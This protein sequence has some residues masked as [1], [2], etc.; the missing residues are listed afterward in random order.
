[1]AGPQA[2][3]A[4]PLKSGSWVQQGWINRRTWVM[5]PAEETPERRRLV[6]TVHTVDAMDRFGRTSRRSGNRMYWPWVLVG[7]AWGVVLLATVT[8]QTRL[9]DHDYLLEHSGLPW[10]AALAVF[11]LCWQVMIAAMML[12]ATLP[13][14]SRDAPAARGSV[15]AAFLTGYAL[16]W[17]WFAAA[18]F[19]GDMVVHLTIESWPWLSTHPAAIGAT[20]LAVAGAVQF[21]PLKRHSLMACRSLLSATV[22]RVPITSDAAWRLG[23]HHGVDCL[24]SGWALM[25][26]MFGLGV[27][28][29]LW[30]VALS[31][32]MVVEKA[33]PSGRWLTPVVGIVLLALAIV[34]WMHPSWLQHVAA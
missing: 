9:I 27:G 3:D 18:A 4:R 10:P 33:M 23:L 34:W 24:G 5:C 28:G 6:R 17:T 21:S 16:V 25:L 30:M 2:L 19:V 14:L 1:M 22:G 20:T 8:N 11:L 29:V 7:C 26:V 32:V 31:I 15:Q 13:I 12:P